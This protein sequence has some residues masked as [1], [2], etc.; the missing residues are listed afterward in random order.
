MDQSDCIFLTRLPRELRDRIYIDA[1]V[2]AEDI[3]I[4][5]LEEDSSTSTSVSDSLKSS[6]INPQEEFPEPP[7]LKTSHQLRSEA[8]STYYQH[9]TFR[10]IV[11]DED[12]SPPLRWLQSLSPYARSCIRSLVIEY[13]ISPAVREELEDDDEYDDNDADGDDQNPLHPQHA[14]LPQTQQTQTST[15]R[16]ALRAILGYHHSCVRRCT[17]FID[18]VGELEGLRL[19]AVRFEVGEMEK[20]LM[21]EQR[22][23]HW[24]RDM[25]E[26]LALGWRRKG[27]GGGECSIV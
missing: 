15:I 10:A 23:R 14:P 20:D 8:I 7:L 11:F 3:N 5:S 6:P 1:L 2:E 4:E 24:K 19:E 25:E 13:Q 27:G 17:K 21:L 26:R 16:A 22:K 9:N 18:S 12:S